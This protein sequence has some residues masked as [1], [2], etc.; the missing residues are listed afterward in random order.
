MFHRFLT[1]PFAPLTA[2]L[3]ALIISLL[4]YTFFRPEMDGRVFFYPDNNGVR[5]GSERR[6]IPA[7][8]DTDGRID[9][10]ISELFLG[11][12][13]L[14]W[15]KAAPRGTQVRHVAVLD[16]TVYV[17]LNARILGT[18]DEMPI[19]FQQALDNLERNIRYNF[20]RVEEIVF[21][22]EGRQVHAPYYAEE[23]VQ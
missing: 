10:F 22:V 9:V 15:S 8:K 2:L 21:T 5:F 12:V 19:T 11:P 1:S 4:V 18:D 7:R 14:E 13:G 17:D 3:V 20:P 6:G 23:R 16:R